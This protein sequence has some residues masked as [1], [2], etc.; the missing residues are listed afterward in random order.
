MR[1]VGLG[2]RGCS[3]RRL[4]SERPGERFP[5]N[6]GEVVFSDIFV[7]QL[8][9]DLS[10]ADP[11]EVLSDLVNPCDAPRRKHPL[12]SPFA[13]W[14]TRS[15]LQTEIRVV[16]KASIVHGTGLIEVLCLGQRRDSKV[17]DMAHPDGSTRL[18]LL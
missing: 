13:W 10:E 11:I 2:R 8:K 17:Y 1:G 5:H 15:V 6:L 12:S 18:D 16:Y 7:E 4:A 14:N 9:A 3:R